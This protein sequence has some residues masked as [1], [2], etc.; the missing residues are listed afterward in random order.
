MDRQTKEPIVKPSCVTGYS[1]NMG[2]VDRI[3]MMIGSILQRRSIRPDTA[4]CV[5]TAI[6]EKKRQ[7]LYICAKCDVSLCV[8]LCFEKYYTLAR[9]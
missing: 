2:V 6:G 5:Q 8:H 4:M 7:S 1:K 3:D 9:F